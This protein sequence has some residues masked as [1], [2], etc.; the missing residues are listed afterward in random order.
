MVLAALRDG[1]SG[2]MLVCRFAYQGLLY[3]R[4][5]VAGQDLDIGF[6]EHT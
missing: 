3:D 1:R 4:L 5:H 2:C 6:L